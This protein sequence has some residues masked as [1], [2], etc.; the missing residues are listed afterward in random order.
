M[1]VLIVEP[2]KYPR[3][4]NIPHTLKAMQE[5]VGGWIARHPIRGATQSR[6][7]ATTKDCS[8]AMP[9]TAGYQRSRSSR[10]RS[11]S[12][13]FRRRTSRTCLTA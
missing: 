12:V 11:S 8:K 13:G 3:E 10:A 1:K 2:G 9:S 6:W 7:F 4:E 5:I